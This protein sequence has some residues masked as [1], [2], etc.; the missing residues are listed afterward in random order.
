V[1]DLLSISKIEDVYTAVSLLAPGV[2]VTFVRSKFLTGRSRTIAEAT[3]EYVVISVVYYA[4]AIPILNLVPWIT[5]Y[6][7]VFLVLVIPALFG[8]LLGISAQLDL[9]SWVLARWPLSLLKLK[10]A[11]PIPTSWDYVFANL[12]SSVWILVTLKSEERVYGYFGGQSFASSDLSRRDLYIEDIRREDWTP[13]EDDG[14]AR[15]IWLSEE[16]I[17]LIEIIPSGETK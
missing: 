5:D 4:V 17:R 7:S 11:H 2:I 12:K 1:S 16:E 14:R 6:R 13:V 10:I 8:C 15:G 9:L 3:M